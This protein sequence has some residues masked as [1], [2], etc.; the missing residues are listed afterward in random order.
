MSYREKTFEEKIKE[1][2]IREKVPIV[3]IAIIAIFFMICGIIAIVPKNNE[4][5]DFNKKGDN[6]S[7]KNAKVYIYYLMGPVIQGRDSA[8]QEIEHFYIAFGEN[9]ELYVI[10]AKNIENIPVWGED[11]NSD[12]DLN[13]LEKVEIKGERK[14]M[15]PALRNMLIIELNDSFGEELATDE[16]LSQVLGNYYLD[17]TP[18]N[19]NF[20]KSVFMLSG[21]F[22]IILVV[23]LFKTL[24]GIKELNTSIEEL[25][26]SGKFK[27]IERDYEN[28]QL[29]QYKKM[30]VDISTKYLFYYT[31]G[32]TIIEFKNMKE[33]SAE[34]KLDQN[35]KRY[36]YIVIETKNGKKYYIAPQTS[37]KKKVIF[38]ELLA[39]IK[40]KIK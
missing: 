2:K 31:N 25:K 36:K 37:K 19:D 29:I 15:Q 5:I 20:G 18:S 39:K 40:T 16:K 35:L 38:E 10:S 23:Y 30:N 14:F 6:T 24:K 27:D 17:I 34:K 3:L 1:I 32:L 13:N 28:G 9:D 33:V 8:T 26:K 7:N 11:V 4:Y 12:E 22:V 21:A